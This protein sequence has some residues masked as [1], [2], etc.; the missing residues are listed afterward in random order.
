MTHLLSGPEL[1]YFGSLCAVFNWLAI[2]FPLFCCSSTNLPR[3]FSIYQNTAWSGQREKL[4][5]ILCQSFKNIIAIISMFII[6]YNLLYL[7]K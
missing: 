5:T 4:I 6:K 1:F 2:P 3:E 7:Q